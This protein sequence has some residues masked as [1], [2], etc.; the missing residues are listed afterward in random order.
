MLTRLYRL[1]LHCYPPAFR[2]RFGDELTSAFEIERRS[3]RSRIGQCWFIVASFAD[4]VRNGLGQRRSG[5]HASIRTGDALMSSLFADLR[6]AGRTLRHNARLT[7][8]ATLTLALGI[9]FATSLFSVAH[10]A[11]VRR[12]PYDGEERIVMLWEFAPDKGATK[13][14]MTPANFLDIRERA[15]AFSHVGGIAPYSATL[16]HGDQSTQVFGRRVTAEVFAALGVMP[17][18]GRPLTHEDERIGNGVAVISHS[19]WQRRFGADPGVVGRTVLLDE[20]QRTVVGIMPPGLRLPADDDDVLIPFVFTKF[21][22]QAR[23]SHWVRVVARMKPGVTLAAAQADATAIGSQ[24]ASEYPEANK[25]ETILVEPVREDMVGGLRPI[26]LTLVAA[27]TL[28]LLIACVNVASLLLAN[29]TARRRELL[30]RVALGAGRL[31][32]LRQL[33]AESLLLALVGGALGLLGA[34]IILQAAGAVLPAALMRSIDP[35]PDPWV[36]VGAVAIGVATAA[37][38]GLAP[39]LGLWKGLSA[40]S[41]ARTTAGSGATRMRRTLVV[42]QVALAVVLLAGAGLVMRSFVRLTSIELGFRTEHLLTFRTELPRQRYAGPMQWKPFF[43]RLIGDLESIPG[44]VRAAGVTGLPLNMGGGS[45]AIFIEG[46]PAPGPNQHTFAIYRLVTPRYFET[47]GIPV[48]EGRDFTAADGIDGMRVGAVNQTLALRM[49]P[50][51]SA[52][53]KRLTFSHTPKAEDWITIV[54]VVRDTHH[55]SLAEPVDI[56][57]Y[58][59]YT[60]DPNWMPP[61]ELVIRT[62]VAPMSIAGAVRERMRGIDARLPVEDLQPLEEVVARSVSEPRFNLFL[63]GA[64]A[65]CALTL[66]AIGIYGLL[67]FTVALRS[68]ELGVRSALGATRRDLSRMV[69]LDGVRLVLSGL[70]IGIGMAAVATRSM[71]ALLFEIEPGDP[72]TFVSVAATLLLMTM[73]ACYLPARR[74]A[75]IDPVVALRTE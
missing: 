24:L 48:V 31:R 65:S 74:A 1:L 17:Q 7:V 10:S 18:Y 9:T 43:D 33:A 67:A 63:L 71:S 4:E 58:S 55:A 3:R 51:Q 11:L 36:L 46:R 73:I 20:L 41:G 57:L 47:I 25:G 16:V 50:G 6:Y 39:I 66:A 38:F 61:V 44:V 42:V 45:N 22:R 29:S 35:R 2:R 72:L 26:L 34:T 40:H 32:L 64:L 69:V 52:I 49:W 30:V 75:R 53:G 27:V 60:Q 37:L 12:L 68:K 21:E 62:S 54:A 15:Q 56:Q 28:V 14:A 70:L 13:G 8:L 5:Q 19:L 59:P 23:R